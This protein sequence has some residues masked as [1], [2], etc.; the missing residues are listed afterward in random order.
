[1]FATKIQWQLWNKEITGLQST[2]MHGRTM[3]S[4]RRRQMNHSCLTYP[5][6]HQKTSCSS[7]IC[8]ENIRS[9]LILEMMRLNTEVFFDATT[10]H[11]INDE[12]NSRSSGKI[13]KQKTLSCFSLS[14]WS[15]MFICFC[16]IIKVD[17]LLLDLT[18]QVIWSFHIRWW[19]IHHFFHPTSTCLRMA[20]SLRLLRSNREVFSLASAKAQTANVLREEVRRG[21]IAAG[22]YLGQ[23]IPVGD[24]SNEAL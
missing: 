24:S 20:F 19:D 2:R 9:N 8:Q 23:H 11:K 5:S 1:M 22:S 15:A 21:T 16:I 12:S 6:G 7:S 3:L 18:K 14:D 17:V 4:S 13:R 10:G